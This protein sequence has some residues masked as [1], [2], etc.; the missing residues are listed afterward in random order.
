MFSELSFWWLV[1]L[2]GVFVAASVHVAL[3]KVVATV[4]V[5]ATFVKE[6]PERWTPLKMIYRN[7]GQFVRRYKEEA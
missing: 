7:E 6:I 2:S 1:R 5:I 3:V 4:A